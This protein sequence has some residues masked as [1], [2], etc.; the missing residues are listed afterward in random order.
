MMRE[1][2]REE[3]CYL[4]IMGHYGNDDIKPT[5]Q[6]PHIILWEYGEWPFDHRL[7]TCPQG[8]TIDF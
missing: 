1:V 8:A 3:N 6:V 5:V 7:D 2:R 4:L